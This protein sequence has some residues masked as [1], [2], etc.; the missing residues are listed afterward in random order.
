MV[1]G[2][3]ATVADSRPA[4]RQAVRRRR[5]RDQPYSFASSAAFN[6]AIGGP[7]T[8]A[9][10]ASSVISRIPTTFAMRSTP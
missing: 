4:L 7:T 8:L 6:V 5:D 2:V 10:A 3:L 9:T 1:T